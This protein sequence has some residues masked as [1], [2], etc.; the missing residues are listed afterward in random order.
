MRFFDLSNSLDSTAQDSTGQVRYESE[1][2]MSETDPEEDLL[3]TLQNKVTN[4]RIILFINFEIFAIKIFDLN[5]T[6]LIVW[7]VRS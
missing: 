1:G 3:L 4:L 7:R 5:K 6:E 2:D